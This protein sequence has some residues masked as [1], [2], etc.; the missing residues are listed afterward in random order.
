ML[1]EITNNS[2]ILQNKE[3]DVTDLNGE[4]V[5][6]NIDKCQYFALDE[7]GSR[8]WEI[9]TKPIKVNEIICTILSEYNIDNETCEKEVTEFLTELKEVG[10]IEIN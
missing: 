2:L 7:V 3:I 4:K 6:M 10:L 9:V 1:N 8:I 5:I